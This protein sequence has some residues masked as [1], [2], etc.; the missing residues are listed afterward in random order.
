LEHSPSNAAAVVAAGCIPRFV[1]LLRTSSSEGVIRATALALG[2]LISGSPGTAATIQAAGG[3]TAL[4]QHASNS[5]ENVRRAV[6]RALRLLAEHAGVA[7]PPA[8]PPPPRAP[9]VCAAP[10]CGATTGLRRCGGCRQVRYCSTACRDAHWRAHRHECKRVQAEA[11][12]ACE[13]AA[14]P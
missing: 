1:Q 7:S 4:Q 13:Q 8:A 10:G 12:A 9:R 5:N 3:G 2:N 14:Q 11:A 6:A